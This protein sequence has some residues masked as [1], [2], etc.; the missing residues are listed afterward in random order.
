MATPIEYDV[1]REI[2]SSKRASLSRLRV[3]YGID[4]KQFENDKNRFVQVWIDEVQDLDLKEIDYQVAAAHMKE[5]AKP[6]T[7]IEEELW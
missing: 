1:L 6:W 5:V 3:K 2:Y 4:T 7:D